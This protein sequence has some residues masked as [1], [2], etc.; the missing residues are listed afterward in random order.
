MSINP[1]EWNGVDFYTHWWKLWSLEQ[2]EKV[3]MFM[4][5]KSKEEEIES[6]ERLQGN[7]IE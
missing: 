5:R 2:K 6:K 7:V 4:L 3:L 1:M